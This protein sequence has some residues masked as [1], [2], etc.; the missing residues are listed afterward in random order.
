MRKNKFWNFKA[1]PEGKGQLTLYG[2]ISNS[3][4]WGDEVTPGQFKKDL[5]GLGAISELEI[6]I[7][8][9]GGDVFAGQA[10]Y[11][12][13]KRHAAHKTVYIDGLAASIASVI[14]MAGDTV[15]MPA[16]A[17]MMI[18]NA[19][20]IAAGN[21]NDFRKLADDMV[22]IDDSIVLTYQDKTTLP[23]EEI[24]E[25]M[26]QETW[27]SA[28]D[29]VR[30]GFADEIEKEKQLAAA[31]DQGSGFLMLNHLEFDLSRYK[32]PP[33][34]EPVAAQSEPEPQASEPDP[35]PAPNE[36]GGNCQ[37]VS[38]STT[39]DPDAAYVWELRKKI[40]QVEDKEHGC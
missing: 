2:D 20:T 35:V 14:A 17:M 36:N 38:D 39:P 40:N 5:E 16:N 28:E 37:P 27:I 4:W 8:S 18:H 7:N 9:G 32:R 3:T 34:I 21:A 22:K 25:M 15:I 26:D 29:A 31:L 13:L 10:I 24:R 12:M 19:W 33:E 6:F 23:E 1:G 30:Y 11:S